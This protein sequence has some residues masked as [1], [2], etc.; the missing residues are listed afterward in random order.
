MTF[1]IPVIILRLSESY[2]KCIHN[3]IFFKIYFKGFAVERPLPSSG[4]LRFFRT[5]ICEL[6]NT[7]YNYSINTN[8]DEELYSKFK[9]LS[10]DLDKLNA[11]IINIEKK[12][13]TASLS[14]F[15][16]AIFS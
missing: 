14:K 10:D 12:N 15:I 1:L 2:Q 13:S 16:F 9:N 8:Y 5:F 7:C 11:T 6:D 4:L 3:C